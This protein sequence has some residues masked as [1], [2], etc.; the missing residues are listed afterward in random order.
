MPMTGPV[1]RNGGG[2]AHK[3]GRV[4]NGRGGK[5]TALDKLTK[6]QSDF[7]SHYLLNGAVGAD[8]A[9]HAGYAHPGVRAY[10]LLRNPVIITAIHSAVLND[11]YV[12]GA[13][14]AKDVLKK[15]ALNENA[16]DKDR[17][18]ACG[19]M[20]EVARLTSRAQEISETLTDRPLNEMTRDELA[21]FIAAE[22]EAIDLL[23]D[24]AQG[25]NVLD[26]TPSV[27]PEPNRDSAETPIE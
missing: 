7:V 21:R 13:V 6:Q 23:E 2:V 17:I 5:F 18:A 16:L 25:P 12:E 8:A 15:I 27:T 19:K 1:P 4:R 22:R 3:Q 9:R 24:A 20:I 10:E 11:F 14:I 26:V